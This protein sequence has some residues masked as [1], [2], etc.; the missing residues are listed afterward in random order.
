MQEIIAK[1]VADARDQTR[2]Q[3]SYWNQDLEQGPSS[4]SGSDEEGERDLLDEGEDDDDSIYEYPGSEDG[5]PPK[6]RR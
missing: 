5:K 6:G 1:V 2:E 3:V 4:I